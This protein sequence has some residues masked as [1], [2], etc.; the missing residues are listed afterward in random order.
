MHSKAFLVWCLPMS[1]IW[2]DVC[3]CLSHF[4]SFYLALGPLLIVG[5]QQHSTT[6]VDEVVECR[7][8]FLGD[9]YFLW[10]SWLLATIWVRTSHRS[11]YLIVLFLQ[12]YDSYSTDVIDHFLESTVLKLTLLTSNENWRFWLPNRNTI[13]L[14]FSILLALILWKLR[15]VYKRNLWGAEFYIVYKRC[16]CFTSTFYN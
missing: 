5:L 15:I 10:S 8:N 12:L 13:R 3:R 16:N 4:S 1:L 14:V 6:V 2:S 11:T 7:N 9:R